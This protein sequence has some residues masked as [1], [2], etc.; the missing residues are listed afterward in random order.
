MKFFALTALLLCLSAPAFAADI[1][2]ENAQ[3]F[4]TS[5][6]MKNG[7]ALF[8]ITNDGKEADKLVAAST[9]V[10]DHAE[11]HEMSEE[12]GVMKMGKV[13]SVTVEAGKSVTF[14]PDGYHVML[15][16]LKAPLKAG[17]EFPLTLKF[18]HAGDVETK[19]TV[20]SR[21]ATPSMDMAH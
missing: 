8:T 20:K 3:A 21:S 16:G 5:E 10:T 1:K 11:I 13:D 12:N 18:E 15:M 7:A 17:S 6:G 2:I 9:P 14:S 4:E 19:V